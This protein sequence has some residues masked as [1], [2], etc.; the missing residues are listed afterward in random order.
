M[1]EKFVTL[2]IGGRLPSAERYRPRS[3]MDS[4]RRPAQCLRTVKLDAAWRRLQGR[5]QWLP[6]CL[7]AATKHDRRYAFDDRGRAA[8]SASR[9]WPRSRMLDSQVADPDS[10]LRRHSR[11]ARTG[12]RPERFQFAAARNHSL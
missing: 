3:S 10:D 9:P 12:A 2:W 5:S 8:R 4:D 1:W 7:P 11:Y 6:P